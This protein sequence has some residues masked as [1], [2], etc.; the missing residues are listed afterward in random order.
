MDFPFQPRNVD[1]ILNVPS[2]FCTGTLTCSGILFD[3]FL[4]FHFF[5]HVCQTVLLAWKRRSNAP[6][7]PTLYI[8]QSFFILSA[9][10]KKGNRRRKRRIFRAM[11][12]YIPLPFLQIDASCI[13]PEKK[14]GERKSILIEKAAF[15]EHWTEEEEEEEDGGFI[16]DYNVSPTPPPFSP[17]PSSSSALE[18][19]FTI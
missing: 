18:I 15:P 11:T 14:E 10:E 6:H 17:P 1:Q 16:R 19:A 9:R 13:F 12:S 3:F 7:F 5:L 8:S 2:R 4:A